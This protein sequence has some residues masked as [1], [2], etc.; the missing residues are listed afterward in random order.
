MKIYSAEYKRIIF[1][2]V[3]TDLG[4]FK[5]HEDGTVQFW[6][7]GLAEWRN[8]SWIKSIWSKGEEILEQVRQA[9]MAKMSG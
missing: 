1:V 7:C 3:V 5:V 9:G 2:D 6:H 4:D 8:E